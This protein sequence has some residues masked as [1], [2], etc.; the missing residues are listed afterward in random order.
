MPSKLK[1]IITQSKHHA[2]TKIVRI[3]L[4]QINLSKKREKFLQEVENYFQNPIQI[5]I[6]KE[7]KAFVILLSYEIHK[8]ILSLSVDIS[9]MLQNDYDENILIDRLKN[10]GQKKFVDETVTLK[11]DEEFYRQQVFCFSF[12]NSKTITK[13]I[14]AFEKFIA[15]EYISLENQKKENEFFWNMLKQKKEDSQ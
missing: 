9:F 15:Q 3:G 12:N 8:H 10:L 7:L 2:K 1:N 11:Q 14:S 6:T 5:S 13:N 4:S